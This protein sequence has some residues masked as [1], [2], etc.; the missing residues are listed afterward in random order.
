MTKDSPRP[1]L[2]DGGWS[3]ACGR[4]V[5]EFWLDSSLDKA[6]ML[7]FFTVLSF[8]PT[9]LAT[10]SMAT[11]FLANNAD[12]VESLLADF[13][14]DYVPDTYQETVRE[15]VMMVI[16]T[17]AG[18]VVGLVAGILVALWSASAYVRAFSRCANSIYG[19][20][21]GRTLIRNFAT[22]LATT[23]VLLLGI[24]LIASSIALNEVVVSTVLGPIA[25]PLG[26]T[27]VLDYLLSVFLP[28]WAW[29]RWPVII[30]LTIV[31]IAVLYY[32][33]P[34]VKQP[35]FRWLSLGASVAMVG[36]ALVSGAFYLYLLF[37]TGL[38]SYG[39]IGTVLALLFALWGG[40]ISLLLGVTVDAEVE[41]ARQL[42]EGV[43][44]EET[45]QLPLRSTR[46]LERQEQTKEKVIER[47]RELREESLGAD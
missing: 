27:D 25:E 15:V 24:V 41:R 2:K 40:N 43:E 19:L 11:L 39:A 47:G 23:L 14:R 1:S 36:L 29:V 32:F 3:Y 37:L 20:R 18:G 13:I 12:L 35:R 9:L 8:A 7:T 46:A 31:L 44:A 21:E 45:I 34:N 6:A 10:Y 17:A 28:I 33:T 22:Q 42:R 5:R 30:L 4:A 16:G 38:S 26:L